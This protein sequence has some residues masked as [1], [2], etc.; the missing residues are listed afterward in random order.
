M[1]KILLQL[2]Q[3]ERLTGMLVARFNSYTSH[4]YHTRLKKV[5][6]TFYVRCAYKPTSNQK[7][8]RFY[9]LFCGYV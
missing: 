2:I 9:L 8:S 6:Y 3:V 1:V 4:F 7:L 5:S